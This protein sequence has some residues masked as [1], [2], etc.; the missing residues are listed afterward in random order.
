[1]RKNKRVRKEENIQENYSG[2][3]LNLR[4]LHSLH[5]QRKVS[6]CKESLLQSNLN[7]KAPDQYFS[8][9]QDGTPTIFY[10]DFNNNGEKLF[11]KAIEE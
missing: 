2:S 11:T 5:T 6:L 10:N 3:P 9:H 8:T 7:P 4:V 1:M